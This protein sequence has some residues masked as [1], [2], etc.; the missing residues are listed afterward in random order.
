MFNI[1][2]DYAL[3]MAETEGY[4]DTHTSK[5][6]RLYKD[7]KRLKDTGEISYLELDNNYLAQF[8]LT[9][10]DLTP[11]IVAK[12]QRIADVGRL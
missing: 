1:P 10:A 9:E 7:I 12:C 2:L 5:I 11:D 8:G 6:N 4:L 3:F